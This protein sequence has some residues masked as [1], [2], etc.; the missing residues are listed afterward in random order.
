MSAINWQY[1]IEMKTNIIFIFY[2]TY[3]LSQFFFCLFNIIYWFKN[4]K[5]EVIDYL[6]G[7]GANIEARSE[8][9]NTALHSAS[10]VSLLKFT[11]NVEQCCK[12]RP[13]KRYQWRD[14]NKGNISEQ[15]TQRKQVS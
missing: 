1:E 11:H 13:T 7:V 10:F 4:G 6:L 9:G 8:G 3:T 5:L 14:N 15:D 12:V 2:N